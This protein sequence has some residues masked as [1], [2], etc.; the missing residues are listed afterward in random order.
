[1]HAQY[2]T[3]EKYSPGN[4]FL[5]PLEP[6]AEP[7][8]D[9]TFVMEANNVGDESA[10]LA[11]EAAEPVVEGVAEEEVKP[12]EEVAVVDNATEAVADS[13]GD[14]IEAVAPVEEVA[15]VEEVTALRSILYSSVEPLGTGGSSSLPLY[16][17]G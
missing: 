9:D 10:P 17:W 12:S 14:A 5:F 8:T 16:K 13:G 6:V 4:S 11:S 15:A 2:G 1:M 3:G 7:A